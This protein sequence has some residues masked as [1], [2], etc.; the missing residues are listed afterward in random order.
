MVLLGPL[1]FEILALDSVATAAADTAIQLVVVAFAVW[2]V[3]ENIEGRRRKWLFA[4][5]ADIARLVISTGQAAVRAG[6]GLPL[7]GETTRLAVASRALSTR[8]TGRPRP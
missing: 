7:D 1:V 8:T 5:R 2:L 4:R 3:V 6:D